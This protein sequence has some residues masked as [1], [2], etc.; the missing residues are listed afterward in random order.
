M[1]IYSTE[2][3]FRY[4]TIQLNFIQQKQREKK[5]AIIENEF[6]EIFKETQNSDVQAFDSDWMKHQSSLMERIR[7]YVPDII[8]MKLSM[9]THVQII[10]SKP[11]T[12]N[13]SCSE[14]RSFYG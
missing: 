6:G 5:I 10:K 7:L 9:V 2:Q 13:N 3:D 1:Y 11:E 14:S 4:P 8:V 12:H